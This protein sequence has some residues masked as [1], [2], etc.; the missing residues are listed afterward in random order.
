MVVIARSGLIKENVSMN[1]VDQV[2]NNTQFPEAPG[3]LDMSAYP[4]LRE[5]SYLKTYLFGINGHTL[6]ITATFFCKFS[7]IE[8]TPMYL[9]ALNLTQGRIQ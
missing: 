4:P 1:T 8:N 7:S 6:D 9:D 2:L 5:N 3:H